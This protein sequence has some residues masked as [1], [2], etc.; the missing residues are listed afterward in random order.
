MRMDRFGFTQKL[1][2]VCLALLLGACASTA[3]LPSASPLPTWRY[4]GSTSYEERVPGL[5]VSHRYASEAGWI[6]VYVY[7]LGR[8]DW[9]TG[10]DDPQFSAHFDGTVEEVRYHARQGTYVGLDVGETR[11]VV[12]SG[13]VF[14]AVRFRFSRDGAPM[15]S[16]TYL[17]GW[18]NQLL[19][20]RIS[21]HAGGGVDIDAV[22]QSFIVENLQSGLARQPRD[23]VL[24]SAAMF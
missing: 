9:A 6:D 15:V 11:D 20:Y 23:L 21:L 18:Q 3:P 12:I 22:A 7:G 5:G 14:R 24:R 13:H 1:F 8:E 10:I 4:A 17:T 19:K 2:V 16:A